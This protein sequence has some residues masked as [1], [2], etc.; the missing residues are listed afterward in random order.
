MI[1]IAWVLYKETVENQYNNV[2]G[3]IVH[4]LLCSQKVNQKSTNVFSDSV[5]KVSISFLRFVSFRL[6]SKG[7]FYLL[8]VIVF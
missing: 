7:L 1:S 6:I 3:L 4:F 8:H 5:T 2:C